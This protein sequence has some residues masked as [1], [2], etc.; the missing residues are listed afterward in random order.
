MTWWYSQGPTSFYPF[1]KCTFVSALTVI[2]GGHTL[3]THL[4]R[5][6]VIT[7]FLYTRANNKSAYPKPI[8]QSVFVMKKKKCSVFISVTQK[9]TLNQELSFILLMKDEYVKHRVEDWIYLSQIMGSI[10][11]MEN[12]AK[13]V[14]TFVD[15]I[16]NKQNHYIIKTT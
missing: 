13:F 5:S 7:L 8:I 2:Q 16:K 11:R 4:L 3:Q 1:F 14:N 12:T 9:L 10:Y 15:F 6:P